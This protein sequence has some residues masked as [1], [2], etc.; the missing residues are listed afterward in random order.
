[1]A[2]ATTSDMVT[3]F[4]ASLYNILGVA[5]GADITAN[6]AL[7]AELGAAD[8]VIDSYL[9]GQYDLPLASVPAQLTGMACRIAWYNLVC[10]RRRDTL[11]ETDRAG[12]DAAIEY[13]E[14]VAK[15]TARLTVSETEAA[16]LS[17]LATMGEDLTGTDANGL[18]CE[19]SWFEG[20]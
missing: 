1:M 8:G 4:G 11:S 15:G 17:E 16:G 7:L 10:Q 2:Y 13:L 18:S 19:Q 20:Y 9:A 12:Y 3:R 5:A 14:K 6:A